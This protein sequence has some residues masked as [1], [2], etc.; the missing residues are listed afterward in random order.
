M[1]TLVVAP[2]PEPERCHEYRPPAR[3]LR[4]VVHRLRIHGHGEG[5]TEDD[6]KGRDV[7]T[8][9]AVDDKVAGQGPEYAVGR[10]IASD[11]GDEGG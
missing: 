3:H 11:D 10:Q 6:D 1:R 4:G 9:D 8:R 7:Q 5:E 2:A